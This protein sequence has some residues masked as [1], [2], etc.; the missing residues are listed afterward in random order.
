MNN[1]NNNNNNNNTYGVDSRNVNYSN[2]Q[3]LS[4]NNVNVNNSSCVLQTP[5]VDYYEQECFNERGSRQISIYNN[6]IY[7]D[8]T[9][10]FYRYNLISSTSNNQSR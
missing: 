10:H 1:N 5:I 9:N 2:R 4:D 7:Q 8:N 3:Q 6:D